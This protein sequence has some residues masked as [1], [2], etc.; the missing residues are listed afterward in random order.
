MAGNCNRLIA[1]NR[2]QA[3]QI[4]ELQQ[5]IA[6]RNDTMNATVEELVSAQAENQ[7]LKAENIE[8]RR[9]GDDAI[10]EIMRITEAATPQKGQDND[11]DSTQ[12]G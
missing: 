1:E 7:R 11:A 6:T 3:E 10:A 12:S 2:R 4:G 9:R 5:E 8:L